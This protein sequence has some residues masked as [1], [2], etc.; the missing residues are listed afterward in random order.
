VDELNICN[1]GLY[2]IVDM[3]AKEN[4]LLKATSK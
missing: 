3:G 1:V 2:A 4:E